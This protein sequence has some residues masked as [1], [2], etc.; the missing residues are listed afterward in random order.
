MYGRV[1]TPTGRKSLNKLPD[2]IRALLIEKSKILESNPIIGEKLSGSLHFLRS[3]HLKHQNV[4]YR[5]AYTIDEKKE[6]III[7]LIGVRENFYDKLKR[8]FQ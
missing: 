7:H 3:F 4:H 8:L 2:K 6:L 1:I 5:L